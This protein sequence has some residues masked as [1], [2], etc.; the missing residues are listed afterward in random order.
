MLGADVV[1]TAGVVE[2]PLDAGADV[3]VGG[4]VVE[5]DALAVVGV[6][7]ADDVVV[8]LGGDGLLPSAIWSAV[9]GP[10]HLGCAVAALG[11]S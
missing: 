4:D 2:G 6:T 7:V 1:A 9:G 10:R 11:R 5:D 8:V 3:G